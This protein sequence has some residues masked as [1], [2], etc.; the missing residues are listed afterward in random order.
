[1]QQLR[2][3]LCSTAGRQVQVLLMAVVEGE[4]EDRQIARLRPLADRDL[5]DRDPR[6]R[7]GFLH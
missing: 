5:S 1:M 6:D 3:R 4:V 7:L 2:S